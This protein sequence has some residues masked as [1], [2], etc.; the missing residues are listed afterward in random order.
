MAGIGTNG[1]DPRPVRVVVFGQSIV[2]DWGNPAATTWRALLRALLTAGHDAVYA[3]QRKNDAVVGLLRARGA[4]AMKAFGRRYPDIVNRTYDLPRGAERSVWFGREVSTADAAIVLD[5]APDGI[6]EEIAAY[7]TPRLLKVL[8]RTGPEREL[9]IPVDR[10]DLILEVET[11][12]AVQV[13]PNRPKTERSRLL[14]VAYEDRTVADLV[15]EAVRSF[16]PERVTPGSLTDPWRYVPEV[17]MPDLYANVSLALLVGGHDEPGFPERVLL[18]VGS[19]CPV[20][21]VTSPGWSGLPGL[22]LSVTTVDWVT[23]AVVSRMRSVSAPLP[24]PPTY[25]AAPIAANLVEDIRRVRT[26]RMGA[27]SAR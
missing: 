13:L 3:E 23:A 5:D 26:E 17:E 1:T 9:P 15:S 22:D 8:A 18:A 10:F 6:F 19:G 11:T 7:D 27:F 4:A 12:R 21:V 2:S 25:D 20:I 24:V 14:V 16:A